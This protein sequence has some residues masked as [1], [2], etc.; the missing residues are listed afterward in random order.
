M[1]PLSSVSYELE[2]LETGEMGR[3]VFEQLIHDRMPFG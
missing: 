3:F 2:D 1:F